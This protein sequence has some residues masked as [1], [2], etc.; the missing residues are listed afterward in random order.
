MAI[1]RGTVTLNR[2]S[3]IPADASKGVFHFQTVGVPAAADY[4]GVING[5]T[6]LYQAFATQFGGNV[7]AA[8]NA[9]QV[10]VAEVTPNGPGVAGDVVSPI[11]ATGSFAI[12]APV[13][14]P[15]PSEVAIVLSFRGEIA[16]LAEESGLT[17]PRSRVRGRTFMGPIGLGAVGFRAVTI[18]P[19]IL[20]VVREQL[21][22]AYDNMTTAMAA[23]SVNLRHCVYSRTAGT[24]ANVVS[25]SVDDE[26]DT[27]RSRGRKPA[28]KMV[29]AVVQG[30]PQ[31]P[32][33]SVDVALAG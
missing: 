31:A 2:K 19:H 25:V 17:R 20:P 12:Q 5:L 3:G 33:D 13:S 11:L 8:A 6:A 7:S 15:Q 10:D 26:F 9:H 21:L 28:L 32:R 24:A 27:V 18:E 14:N 29:R 30:A 23:A 16:G 1:L 22:D 4:T